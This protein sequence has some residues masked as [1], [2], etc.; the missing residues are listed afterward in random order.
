LA[1][2]M[3][4]KVLQIDCRCR[5]LFGLKPFF[6][7]LFFGCFEDSLVVTATHVQSNAR[8]NP[9]NQLALV[10]KSMFSHIADAAP[11]SV[12]VKGLEGAVCPSRMLKTQGN[13]M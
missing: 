6:F 9:G 10:A 12:Q 1:E 8:Q 4:Q 3:A 11:R 2:R 13:E 7:S 5:Q